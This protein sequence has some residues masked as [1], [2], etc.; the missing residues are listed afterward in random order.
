VLGRERAAA[1]CAAY[2]VRDAGNF[3]GGTT[4]LH[5]VG[6]QPRGEFAAERAALLRARA[7]RPAPGTDRKR[8]AAWNGLA[9]SGLARAGSVL[10]E[11]TLVGAAAA[12]AEFALRR[13][14]GSDGRLHRIWDG[15]RAYVPAFLDDH[16]GLLEALLDLH[17]TGAGDRFLA[18]ALG[19]AEAIAERF[20]DADEGDLF[21][22]PADADPLV[23]RP[24]SDHD[25]A[26]PGSTGW[27]VLGCLRLATL[28]GRTDLRRIVDRVLRTHAY[29]LERAPESE[30]TLAR[31]ALLAEAGL[32]VAV[33][34]GEPDAAETRALAARA[35]R[36]LGPEDGVVVVRPGAPAPPG[37]DPT[38][39]AGREP[40]PGR[41]TAW[42][43]RGVAC[44]LPVTEPEALAPLGPPA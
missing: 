7:S 31:A 17:R 2:G 19:L 9:I 3:E 4:V 27:A 36:V 1:F 43:C 12:A 11:A 23:Q 28:A 26:T 40:A 10:G 33:I 6:R 35:R 21:L 16:A 14:R 25:G 32:S 38:W 29:V 18:A 34:A 41:P 15:E 24:R 30:P 20:Y 44:S 5:E 8:I 22:T 13:L 37:L 39:L 42:V